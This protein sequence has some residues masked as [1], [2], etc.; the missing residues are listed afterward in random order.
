[1][2]QQNCP[3]FETSGFDDRGTIYL[4]LQGFWIFHYEMLTTTVMRGD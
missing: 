1:M 4:L 2:E 3:V